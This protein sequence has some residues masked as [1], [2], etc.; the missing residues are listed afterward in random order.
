MNFM[1]NIGWE[2]YG[3][4]FGVSLTMIMAVVMFM[5]VM[6]SEHKNGTLNHVDGM[7]GDEGDD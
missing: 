1:T 7:A 4:N 5:Y 2:F 3:I 6:L